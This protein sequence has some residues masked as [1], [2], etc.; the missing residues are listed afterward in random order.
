MQIS[1]LHIIHCCAA[2]SRSLT[3]CFTYLISPQWTMNNS[4]CISGAALWFRTG[5]EDVQ[6]DSNTSTGNQTTT[7]FHFTNTHDWKCLCEER[8]RKILQSTVWC[9]TSARQLY[10]EILVYS[11]QAQNHVCVEILDYKNDFCKAVNQEHLWS[12]CLIIELILMAWFCYWVRLFPHLD[13]INL[14]SAQFEGA[15]IIGSNPYS[16]TIRPPQLGQFNI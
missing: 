8:D 3:D 4:N 9:D 16:G 2:G 12:R 6:R 11:N 10:Q 15:K 1:S 13:R 7:Q 14:Y 5:W